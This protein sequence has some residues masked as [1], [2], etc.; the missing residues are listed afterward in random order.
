[1]NKKKLP[2]NSSAKPWALISLP[3]FPV[4]AAKVMQLLADNRTGL[5]ELAD[6]IRADVAFSAEVLTLANCSLFALRTEIKTVLHA[7]TVLGT[8]RVK[9]IAMTVGLRSYLTD[10]L[11]LP[12]LLACWRHSLACAILCEDLASAAFMERD[13]AYLAGL[14][15]DVGRLAL[16]V[17]EPLKYSNL[18]RESEERAMDVRA[19]EKE[20]FGVDHCQAGRWMTQQWKLP[21]HFA[22]VAA[23]HHDAVSPEQFD[24]IAVVQLGCQLADSIGFWAVRPFHL[25]SFE[26]IVESLPHA[27]SK[28]LPRS[29]EDLALRIATRI[30]ALDAGLS[31]ITKSEATAI[32]SSVDVLS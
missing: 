25:R 10:S 12:A 22:E 14:L 31:L 5:K 20:L 1:M 30:N 26:D 11:K 21:S 24:M 18:I 4:V 13:E 23:R 32:G 27:V 15:H 19:R 16:T 7:T 29:R 2:A 9:A 3:P 6:I 28:H 17:V 8:N